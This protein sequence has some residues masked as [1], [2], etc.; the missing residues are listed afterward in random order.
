MHLSFKQELSFEKERL[1]EEW[2]ERLEKIKK[3]GV[4]SLKMVE[5]ELKDMAEELSLERKKNKDMR[6]ENGKV[7]DDLK[8]SVKELREDNCNK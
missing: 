4:E 2:E 1:N 5:S 7:V 8:Q 3:K 6:V